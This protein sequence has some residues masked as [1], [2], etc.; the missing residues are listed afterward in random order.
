MTSPADIVSYLKTLGSYDDAQ[1]VT[2]KIGRTT[3]P[4]ARYTD[5]GQPRIY[6]AGLVPRHYLRSSRVA[7]IVPGDNL[8]WYVASY[9]LNAAPHGKFHPFGPAFYLA[10]WNTPD[11]LRIDHHESRPYRRQH[12]QI[13]PAA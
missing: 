3:Y 13:N 2:V 5:N 1:P 8:D 4:A 11:G 12:I 10:L 7:F 6:V 9:Y